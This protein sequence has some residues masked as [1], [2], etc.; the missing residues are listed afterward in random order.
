MRGLSPPCH[1][2]DVCAPEAGAAACWR[3]WCATRGL[4]GDFDPLTPICTPPSRRFARVIATTCATVAT[5][6]VLVERV[7][8]LAVLI[9]GGR[10][11]VVH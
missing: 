3:R 6:R 7:M 11:D 2:A 8:E 5:D 9:E 4:D 1:C 10:H